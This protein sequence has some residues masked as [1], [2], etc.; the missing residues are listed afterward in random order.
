MHSPIHSDQQLN[1]QTIALQS[2]LSNGQQTIMSQA[3]S[4]QT[5]IVNRTDNSP[6]FKRSMRQRTNVLVEPQYASLVPVSNEVNYFSANE[7][8]NGVPR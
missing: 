1:P 6:M 5:V 2:Y 7:S 4:G 8:N 3:N